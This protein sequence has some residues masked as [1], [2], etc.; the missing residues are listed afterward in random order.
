MPRYSPSSSLVFSTLRALRFLYAGSVTFFSATMRRNS[1]F[2]IAVCMSEAMSAAVAPVPGSVE[3]VRVGEAGVV[4]AQLG[5]PLVHL[6]DERRHR[7]AHVLGECV[8]RVVGGGNKRKFEELPH[9]E[10]LACSQAKRVVHVRGGLRDRHLVVEVRPVEHHERDHDLGD[11]RHRS[12][13]RGLARPQRP[14][15]RALEQPR[16]RSMS[17]AADEVTVGRAKSDAADLVGCEPR[18]HCGRGAAA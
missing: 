10:R 7:P 4:Q 15:L 14:P 8:R 3:T 2:F 1:G 11:A 16:G 6:S 17:G 13:G 12:A 5:R 18:S 9:R